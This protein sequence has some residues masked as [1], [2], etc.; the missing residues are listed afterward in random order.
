MY[1]FI[2]QIIIML[3]LGAV[4]YLIARVAPR[5][6]D[7]HD[8]TRTPHLFDK[9]GSKIPLNEIDFAAS[10]FLEKTLRKIKLLLMKW[11]N[12]V[13]GHI[14]KIKK[15]NGNGLNKEAKPNLFEEVKEEN[16]Q[17]VKE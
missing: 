9:L 5:V 11:D 10:A 6:G 13:S 1:T 17:E 4:I 14:N 3:S 12:I 2:L 8:Y 15:T 7:V 16:S